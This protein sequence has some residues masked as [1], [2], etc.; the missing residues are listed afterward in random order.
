MLQSQKAILS[1]LLAGTILF[2]VSCSSSDTTGETNPADP[3][4]GE[5]ITEA[6]E[7]EPEYI[8]WE[9]LPE[10][11][12]DGFTFQIIESQPDAITGAIYVHGNAEEQTGEA[13]NDAIY[14]RNRAVEERFDVVITTEVNS[15]KAANVLQK[16]VT[17]GDNTYALGMDTPG[18]M[19]GMMMKNSLLN[20]MHVEHMDM[21]RPWYNQKQ[22]ENFTIQD[23]L[24][25][26]M[27]DFAYSTLMFG[28]CL[29]YNLDIA[30]EN[31]LPDIYETVVNGEWTLDTMHEHT[32]GAAQDLNGDGMM[33]EDDDQFV[34][35]IR[36]S[37]NMM[38]FMFC[39]DANFMKYDA[40]AGIFLNTFDVEK[41]QTIVEK[42]YNI[43]YDENRGIVAKDYE[44]LFNDGRLLM[45]T[46]YI[47]GCINHQDME[48]NFTPIPNPK[49]DAA[50]ESY[51]SMMT[52]S[53]LSMGIPN[54]VSNPSAVGLVI[55]AMSEHSAGELNEAVYD[56]VLSYQTMRTEQAMEILQ[57]IHKSLIVDFGYLT[58]TGS[59]DKLKWV[60]GDL[61]VTKKSTDVA[62]HYAKYENALENFFTTLLD[63]IAALD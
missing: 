43:F 39:C 2:T 55:E 49:F 1:L 11:T 22:V 17:A 6:V 37:G 62:S 10:E 16:A 21:T 58:A 57:I 12:L 19:Y 31:G 32:A 48:D 18:N 40:Q 23:K 14:N 54:T 63:D 44:K 34:F 13:I 30:E 36:N 51:L 47:G 15:G 28:G 29:V 50:Q 56:R 8:M 38:N 52:G 41:V 5:I 27:G 59:A 60:V 20:L 4:A 46:A 3:Q 35:A 53:V 61:V 24:Y 7:T 33:L 25:I 42:T 45:R 9:H 26:F